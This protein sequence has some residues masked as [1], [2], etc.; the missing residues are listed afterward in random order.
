M[1]LPEISIIFSSLA[2]SAIQR[3]QR[4]IV[5]LILKDDT[6]NFDTK[7]YKSVTE[8]QSSDWTAKN[9][10]YIKRAFLGTPSKV[11][12]ER[13]STS[14]TDY[15]AAL[16]RL[17]SKR[18]NYLAVPGIEQ[19]DVSTIETQ[20]KTWRDNQ[21][22]TFKAVLP[23]VA[24]DHEGVINFSTEGIKVRGITDPFTASEYTARIAGVLA[25]LPLTR[26]STYYVLPE[27]EA[28]QESSDPDADI[29]AGKLI[30]INDGE[31]IKIAR[32][33]NSLTTTTTQKGADWKK[34][35]IIE[36]RD[37]WMDD[38]TRTFEEHYVGKVNNSYDNQV[39]F[40]TAVNA[41]SRSLE[42][43]VLDPSAENT[44]GVDVEE[45]RLAWESIGTDTST[46]DDQKVKEMSFQSNVFLGGSLKFL[47]AME[48]MKMK[49]KV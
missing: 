24:A 15:N 39:L 34:I 1:G 31:K 16:T 38:V 20:I 5:S 4:G 3:S 19:A 11:I 17:A 7:E 35:K 18:W 14:A 37:L 44:V 25:G 47:D 22:K 45:Q 13:I 8:V 12:V 42:G 32:G 29:D 33:V 28:I 48:D 6:G 27:V 23:N 9:L 21:K 36:S 46:W 40:I 2:V 10:D 43:D 49:I 30:L 41:Y 26:S